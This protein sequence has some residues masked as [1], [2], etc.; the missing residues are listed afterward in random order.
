MDELRRFD[1]ETAEADFLFGPD[2]PGYIRELRSQA[3]TLWAANQEY[4][5]G[6][7]T[8]PSGYD[9]VAVINK[10]E[11]AKQWLLQQFEKQE[12]KNVFNNY[13]NINGADA[14]M[15]AHEART[16]ASLAF[17]FAVVVSFGAVIYAVIDYNYP[18]DP[19]WIE[20]HVTDPRIINGFRAKEANWEG[21]SQQ[22]I[23]GYI[24]QTFRER[25]ERYLRLLSVGGAAISSIMVLVVSG[26]LLRSRARQ[27]DGITR[28]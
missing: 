11:A 1:S 9:H 4:R 19:A 5:E 23:A 13:L 27:V 18:V 7:Q 14:F 12:P 22:E 10:K 26:V 25:R 3:V 8:F 15:G 17:A 21:H 2:V 6:S 20:N 28:R 16:I 24:A